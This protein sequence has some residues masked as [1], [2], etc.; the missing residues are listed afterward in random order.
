M[1][2]GT[3]LQPAA[4]L[5]L[6]QLKSMRV[7]ESMLS[8]RLM[9]PGA[10]V[11]VGGDAFRSGLLSIEQSRAL[12]PLLHRDPMVCTNELFLPMPRR[13]FQ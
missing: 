12:V 10:C 6:T 5:K 9:K 7:L 13:E 8:A 2:S 4:P 3:L 11:G 1:L